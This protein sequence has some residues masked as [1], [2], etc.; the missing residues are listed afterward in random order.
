MLKEFKE[1]VFKGNVLD[2]VIVVVMGVV[3][4]KIVIFLV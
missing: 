4:N 3:F 1:F 2:L